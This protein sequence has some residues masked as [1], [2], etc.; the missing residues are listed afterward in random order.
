MRII[1][2]GDGCPVI[3]I[4]IKIAKHYNLEIIIV[5]DYSHDIWDNYAT[6]ITVDEGR[7]SVDLYIVN[8]VKKNDIVITQDY[9]L[10]ALVLTKNAKCINQNG[11]I[12]SS[13]NI[14]HLLTQRHLNQQLRKKHKYFTTIKK[15]NSKQD[16]CF[17]QNI[18][19]LIE[20]TLN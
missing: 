7:D 2:D 9:G 12:I 10:A 11:K 14:D 1:I 16:K 19:Y 18:K 3:D 17:E 6:I 5:K 8:N 13:Q 15:R 4:A 20:S